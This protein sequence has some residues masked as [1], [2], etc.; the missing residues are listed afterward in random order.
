VHPSHQPHRQQFVDPRSQAPSRPHPSVHVTGRS[1]PLANG[2]H[3]TDGD[4]GP[5]A[6]LLAVIDCENIAARFTRVVIASGDGAFRWAAAA[7]AAAGC[8]GRCCRK[9]G[10]L[11]RELVTRCIGMGLV[12][13]ELAVAYCA[14]VERI[15]WPTAAGVS[16]DGACGGC[17]DRSEGAAVGVARGFHGERM[18]HRV[19][20]P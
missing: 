20:C 2:R 16:D 1:L 13:G 3:G 18:R 17:A 4:D 19:P 7:L 14:A 9:P 8:P 11:E 6:E 12:S 15:E 10:R 5:D